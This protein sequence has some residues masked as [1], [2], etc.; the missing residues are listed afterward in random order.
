[1][2]D[3]DEPKISQIDKHEE[4][5]TRKEFLKKIGVG[6]GVVGFGIATGETAL[7]ALDPK[8][9]NRIATQHLIRHLLRDPDKASEFFVNPHDVAAEFGAKLSDQDVD[10]I[11]EGLIKISKG[12]QDKSQTAP[13]QPSTRQMRRQGDAWSKSPGFSKFGGGWTH[14]AKRGGT[15]Q[16]APQ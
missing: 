4:K 3:K 6:A 12:P 15:L 13:K 5:V 1:M 7:A 11:Q 16:K 14:S 9:D 8:A 2:K 10:R